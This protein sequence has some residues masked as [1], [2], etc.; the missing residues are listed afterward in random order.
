MAVAEARR[1]RAP[2]GL[3]QT[4]GSRYSISLRGKIVVTQSH[5][6]FIAICAISLAFM[7]TLVARR[8]D[9]LQCVA[10][11]IEDGESA[12]IS[13]SEPT[14]PDLPIVAPG[15]SICKSTALPASSS[16]TRS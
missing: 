8:Y 1:A 4:V 11:E 13:A 6:L 5:T 2:T 15:W 3:T 14:A 7:P 10:M 16:T 12:A 9:T